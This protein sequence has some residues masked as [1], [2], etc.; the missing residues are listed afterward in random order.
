M[1]REVQW[2]RSSISEM[3]DT[4]SLNENGGG[5]NCTHSNSVFEIESSLSEERRKLRAQMK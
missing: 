4:C 3:V 5:I 1:E 2:S